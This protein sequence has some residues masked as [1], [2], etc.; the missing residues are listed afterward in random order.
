MSWILHPTNVLKVGG[1][2]LLLLGLIGFT[3][4]TNSIEFFNLDAGENVAHTALGIVGL[5]VGFGIKDVRM[6][7]WLVGV[8]AITGLLFGIWG[9]VLPAGSFTQGNFYG[10]ANLENPADNVLHLL[11]GIWTAASFLTYKP[12]AMSETRA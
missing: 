12:M 1:A 8:L 11:V 10:L 6:H 2:V 9:F 3:G 5:A 7:K 4:V